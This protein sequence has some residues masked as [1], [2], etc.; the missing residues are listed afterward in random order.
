MP[1]TKSAE[2]AL[3]QTEKRRLHNRTI[4]K[5]LKV[6]VKKFQTTLTGGTPE[7]RLTEFKSAAKKLDK[8]AAKHVIHKNRAARLKSQLARQL[9]APPKK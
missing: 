1:H 4:K 7:Q 8:A 3:R 2:K 6:Q 9:T 5:A